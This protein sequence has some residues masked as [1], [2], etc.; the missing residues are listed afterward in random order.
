M[1]VGGR[2]GRKEPKGLMTNKRRVF[3]L[4]AGFTRAFI[5]AAPLVE[6]QYDIASLVGVDPVSWTPH[7]WGGKEHPRC[8]RAVGGTH[9]SSGNA[10]SS[11]FAKDGRPRS[12]D[13]SSSRRP[14][15]S[16]TG[17]ARPTVMRGTA[18]TA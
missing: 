18:G 3:F 14:S 12:S 5:P 7:G 15:A 11:W 1:G 4:G 13:G 2:K 10:S 8:R 9:R 17:C 6:D 16:G